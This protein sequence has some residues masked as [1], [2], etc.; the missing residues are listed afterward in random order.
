MGDRFLQQ[1]NVLYKPV[2]LG[3]VPAIILAAWAGQNV[4]VQ[5]TV[6]VHPRLAQTQMHHW[7]LGRYAVKRS[8]MEN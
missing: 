8:C 1:H 4:S 3:L 2:K 7:V 6:P 5:H